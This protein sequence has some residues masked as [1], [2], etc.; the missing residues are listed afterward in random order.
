MYNYRRT[1]SCYLI[2]QALCFFLLFQGSVIAQALPLP[3][4]RIRQ[5]AG[6]TRSR[7]EA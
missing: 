1:T 3:P 7:G 2:S 6:L 5:G 4:K